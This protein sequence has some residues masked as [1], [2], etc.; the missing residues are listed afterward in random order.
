AQCTLCAEIPI[1]SI[2]ALVLFNSGC[3]TDSMTHKMAYLC[4]ADCVDLDEPVGLQLG[5][6]GSRT[7]INFGARA[8]VQIG[9]LRTDHYF[10]V[11]DIDK[12]DVILGTTFCREH[13]VVLNFG[14]NLVTVNGQPIR[15]F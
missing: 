7:R 2:K 3:T 14:N 11:V 5:T 10:D 9:Q 15:L 13:N 12:Y 8:T 4:R 1:N 6:K